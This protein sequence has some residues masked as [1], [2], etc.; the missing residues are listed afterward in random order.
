MR[1]GNVVF[2]K[3]EFSSVIVMVDGSKVGVIGGG[4]GVVE[5]G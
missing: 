5:W 4:I 2:G 3:F 1:I